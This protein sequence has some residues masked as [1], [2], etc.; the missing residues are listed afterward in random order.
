MI[1]GGS[2]FISIFVTADKK[3]RSEFRS[4][5]AKEFKKMYFAFLLLRLNV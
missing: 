2:E 3:I 1:S 5:T 4:S